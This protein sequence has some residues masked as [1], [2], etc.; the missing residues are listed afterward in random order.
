MSTGYSARLFISGSATG[1]RETQ[2]HLCAHVKYSGR[3]VGG[4]ISVSEGVNMQDVVSPGKE[5]LSL[6]T[7]GKTNQDC[8][9]PL[10]QIRAQPKL[11]Q[12]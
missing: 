10:L 6:T 3:C 8:D 12:G 1:I 7:E 11:W 4:C 2:R 5:R 9:P